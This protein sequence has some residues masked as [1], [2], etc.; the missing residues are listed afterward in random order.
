MVFLLLSGMGLVLP[1]MPLYVRSLGADYNATGFLLA[2]FGFARLFGDLIG[3]SIVDRKGERWTAVRGMLLLILCSALTG[4]AP[5]YGFALVWWT[6][7]GIGNAVTMSAMFSYILKVAP[8]DQVARTL[9]FFFGAFNIGVIAGSGVGGIVADTFGIGS[10]LYV[11]AGVLVV[12][13]GYYLR[14]VPDLPARPVPAVAGIGTVTGDVGPTPPEASF[15]IRDLLRVLPFV[16]ALALNFTYLWMVATVFNTLLPLFARDGLGMSPAA[17]GVVLSIT[18]ASEFFVLFPA[19]TLADRHGR[20][21]V[22]L[23]SL[24]GLAVVTAAVGWSEEPWMLAALMA[25]LALFSGVAGVPPAAILSDVV[26]PEH[27]GR[28]VGAF[29]LCGDLGFFLGPLVA[30]ATS[31]AFGFRTAFAICAIPTAA[32]FVLTWLTPETLGWRDRNS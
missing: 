18:V 13:V 9:S 19:G 26:P 1:I 29:R 8:K 31:E 12:A 20:K 4:L 15:A 22:L 21:P 23:P 2:C 6:L 25:V 30:G 10:P 27:S 16:T 17:V 3:G 7:A 11:Y 32:A 5:N 24:L 14:L 28:G